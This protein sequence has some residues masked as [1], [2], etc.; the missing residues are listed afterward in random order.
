MI[1]EHP[2]LMQSPLSKR[3]ICLS[4]GQPLVGGPELLLGSVPAADHDKAAAAVK[5]RL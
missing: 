4:C 2:R 5:E 1:C 3:V